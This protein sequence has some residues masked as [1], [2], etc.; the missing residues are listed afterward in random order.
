MSKVRTGR[1]VLRT[2]DERLLAGRARYIANLEAVGAFEG[3]LTCVFVRSQVPH[4][5]VVTVDG[6]GAI[7]SEGV[8]AFLTGADLGLD[9][10]LAGSLVP[11][12]FARPVL[13]EEVVR[14]AGEPVAMLVAESP[15]A[16]IDALELVSVDIDPLPHV[17]DPARAVHPS[18][19]LLFPEHGSNVAYS[20]DAGKE[21][22][23][24]EGAD[25]VATGTFVNQRLI[26]TPMETNACAARPDGQGGVEMW[27]STQIPFDV[28]SDVADALE[29]SPSK[30]RVIA[31][32]VG[33]GFGA[34]L[35]VYPEYL[36]VAAAAVKLG[37][38][39]RWVE[40][41]SESMQSLTHGR[42]QVQDVRIG[43]TRDGRII[44][45]E[46]DL[47]A[48]MGAYPAPGQYLPSNTY[49]MASGVYDIPHIAFK[50]DLVVTNA[51]PIGPYRGAGRPEAAAMI[52]RVV[53]LLADEL[54]MDPI[55]LRRRNLIAPD[56]F[57]FETATGARYDSGD[58]AR[59]L[60]EALR[61]AGYDELLRE[62]RERR[63]R[64]D[65]VQLGV[66]VATYAE[67]T[68]FGGREYASVEVRDDGGITVMSGLSPHGQGHETS[69]AQIVA[70]ALDVP[71]ERVEV[72]HSDTGRVPR[73]EGTWASRSLQVGGSAV[74]GACEALLEHAREDGLK[75]GLRAEFDF[76]QRDSTYPSG[77]HVA[78]VEVDIETGGVQ[79]RRLIAVD[80]AG[81]ILNPLLA[82]GQVHGGAVQGIAQALFEEVPFD[83]WGNQLAADLATYAVPSAADLPSFETAFVETPTD[84]NPLGA[85]GIGESAALGAVPAVQNAVVDALSH[86]G[87]R[88]VDMPAT[89]ERVWRAIRDAAAVGSPTD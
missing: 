14:F 42:A 61:I 65:V 57:P 25:V 6:S 28:R 49:L 88:H 69:L 85:K 70:D 10:Q 35:T 27:V 40:S 67:V 15:E 43:A 72:V 22:D 63:D 87:V 41:R 8:V 86:L 7:D 26:P 54:G 83:E 34:K 9:P 79:L 84:L 52:E 80:D 39:V 2:E 3:L 64:G 20:F 38:P 71:I 58:Y 78:V 21:G 32:D 47:I 56:R 30:V 18:S 11:D 51:P 19:P 23:P 4:G 62:Q 59:A 82:E 50:A 60:D 16:A 12:L 74:L 68:S 66:G 77:T 75:P 44:G 48:D 81:T 55:E 46:V 37:R 89:P 36:A 17:T 33:G 5:R 73:G 1:S 53:D 76:E 13:A 29:L 45:L 31:P 24:L